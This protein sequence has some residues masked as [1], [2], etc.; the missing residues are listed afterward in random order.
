[1]RLQVRRRNE[2][3]VLGDA[4]CP[5]CYHLPR[6]TSASGH[7]RR[8]DRPPGT[9]GLPR[10]ADIFGACRNVSKVPKSDLCVNGDLGLTTRS[11]AALEPPRFISRMLTCQAY[12]CPSSSLVM[13][14]GLYVPGLHPMA[15]RAW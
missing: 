10:Q 11:E 3:P 7:S 14:P 5:C 13:V 8:F 2:S 4:G 6:G 9:S 12:I 1:M 15:L